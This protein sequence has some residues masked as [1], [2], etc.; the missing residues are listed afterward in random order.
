MTIKHIVISGGGPPGIIAYG[1]YKE[2]EK[3][4]VL[5]HQR[6]KIYLRVFY[7]SGIISISHP[8]L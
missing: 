5:E 7:G 6:Y 4:R 2:L 3:K 1:V 8:K